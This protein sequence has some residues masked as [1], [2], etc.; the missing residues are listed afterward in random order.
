MK[1][2]DDVLVS[3]A[4]QNC[5]T[6]ITLICSEKRVFQ[7][8]RT[9][10]FQRSMGKTG[11]TRMGRMMRGAFFGAVL[12]VLAPLH[13]SAHPHVFVK[14]ESEILYAADGSVTAIRHRWNFDEAYSAFAVQGLD[15]NNDGKFTPDELADLAKVNIESLHEF[16]FFTV[17][18]AN[19]KKQGFSQPVEYGLSFDGKILT[20]SFTLPLKAPS[21][22]QKSFG[23]E[24]FDET[25]FVSFTWNEGVNAVRMTAAPTGCALTV[26][27]PS[28]ATAPQQPA[29]SEDFFASQ[30][31]QAVGAQFANKALVAC[32]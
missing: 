23:L 22:A 15:T 28:A 3:T 12:S 18:R 14:A 4:T 31:G 27:R 7:A 24:V 5:S 25:Y 32:P 26:S 17:A 10:E 21:P 13:V 2:A 19:G 6:L 9:K 11:Q 30:A 20:L 1:L 16:G 8:E 29:L